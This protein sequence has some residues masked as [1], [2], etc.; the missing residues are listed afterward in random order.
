MVTA[1]SE[2][3]YP[4]IPLSPGP[5]LAVEVR[6]LDRSDS[7]TKLEVRMGVRPLPP[8]LAARKQAYF[9]TSFGVGMEQISAPAETRR[10]P[11]PGGANSGKKGLAVLPRLVL[12]IGPTLV[13]GMSAG[14]ALEGP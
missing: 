6:E 7:K 8:C 5:I 11:A 2:T 9:H 3:E 1:V 10:S 14:S 12:S 13:R 4:E